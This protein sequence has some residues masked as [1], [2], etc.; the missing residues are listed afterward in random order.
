MIDPMREEGGGEGSR[1]KK[2]GCGEIV[3]NKS[4]EAF[5]IGV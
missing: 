4:N 2:K 1:E 5:W 3:P